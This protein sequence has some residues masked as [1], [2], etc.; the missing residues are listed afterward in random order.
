MICLDAS[1]AVKWIFREEDSENALSLARN[2]MLKGEP[3]VAPHLLPFEVVNAIRQRTRREAIREDDVK[4][5]LA[6]FFETPITLAPAGRMGRITFHRRALELAAQFG[7]PA[8]YDAH[9]LALAEMRRCPLWT[10]DR[11]LVNAL[12]GRFPLLRWLGDYTAA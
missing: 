9:Y 10:S 11:R 1:V 12:D 8:A 3:I 4:R 2:S 6:D 5:M 7:L